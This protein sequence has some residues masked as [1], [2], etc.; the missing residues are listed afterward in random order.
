MRVLFSWLKDYVDI[1]LTPEDLAQKLTMAGLEVT[2]LSKVDDNAV[3]EI[4]I[5]PNRTDCLNMVGIARE[6]AAITGKTLK[7]PKISSI[8][9]IS[10]LSIPISVEDKKLCPYYLGRVIK[11][12]TVGPSPEWL[13]E[14]LEMMGV[15]SVNNIVDITNFCLLELGQPLHAFD[16]YKLEG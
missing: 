13:K 8:R 5:T 9:G 16:L 14:R 1:R 3:M 12:V 11:N 15:R 2:S 4:E 10:S 6:V 7:A